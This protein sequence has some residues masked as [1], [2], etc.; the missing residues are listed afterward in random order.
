M[1]ESGHSKFQLKPKGNGFALFN[2]KQNTTFNEYYEINTG[3]SDRSKYFEIERWGPEWGRRLYDN[4]T[5]AKWWRKNSG[6]QGANSANILRCSGILKLCLLTALQF[7]LNSCDTT[8]E[9]T[10]NNFTPT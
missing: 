4:L 7:F 5:P 9:Q 10:G 1:S 2:G 6:Y 3:Y 8:G